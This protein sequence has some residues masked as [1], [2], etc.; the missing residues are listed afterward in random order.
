MRHNNYNDF[1][2]ELLIPDLPRGLLTTVNNKTDFN[3]ADDNWTIIFDK[4][5]GYRPLKMSKVEGE[6]ELRNKWV[7]ILEASITD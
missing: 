7:S 5:N 6:K 3:L 2:G 4:L 1:V